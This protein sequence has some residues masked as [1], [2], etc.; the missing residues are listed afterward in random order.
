MSGGHWNYNDQ[1]LVWDFDEF[2]KYK[3]I[4]EMAAKCFHE[5][6]YAICGDSNQETAE[7]SLYKIVEEYGE[8]IWGE[9]S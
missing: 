7:K 1:K 9:S 5:V 3:L 6:D 2:E 8:K 4:M